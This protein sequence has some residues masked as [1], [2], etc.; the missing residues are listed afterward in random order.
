MKRA[1]LPILLAVPVLYVAACGSTENPPV[2]Q[3]TAGTGN[4]AQAG[5]V[6]TSGSTTTGGNTGTS[7]STSTAGQTTTG[8][9]SAGSGSGGASAG[10]A[11]GGTGGGSAGG[12]M[13]GGTGGSSAGTGG[14]SGGTA[15]AG[16]GG[17]DVSV[18]KLNGM[19]VMTP[20]EDTPSTDD[21]NSGGWI[22]EGQTHGCVGGQLDTDVAATKTLLDFPVTGEAGKVYVAT[23]HFY[24]VMEPKVYG[25]SAT[26]EAGAT[27]PNVGATPSTP[28]PFA[29]APAGATYPESHYNTYELHIIDNMGKELKQYYINS[30]TQEGH[31]TFG[32]NYERKIEVVGGGKV[33]VRI[34]DTNCRQIKNCGTG[35]YPCA[36]KARTID[37]SGASPMPTGLQQPGLGKAADH[38]GQWF[39]INVKNIV[40]K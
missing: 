19:L 21:C 27:R 1:S 31:Y 29:T 11:S 3:G 28:D 10:S 37:L 34:L 33:H 15:G 4:T 23:M 2:V 14:A 39:F 32:I 17:A 26:R 35:G 30:D 25:N 6:G 12:A 7:G 36:S 24:G 20:C 40:P 5:T 38:A 18:G 9:A 13:S 22:Y 16:G 8:G